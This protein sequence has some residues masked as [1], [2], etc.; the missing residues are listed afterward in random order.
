MDTRAAGRLPRDSR[1][2][3]RDA[4]PPPHRLMHRSKHKSH[5]GS[6]SSRFTPSN[7]VRGTNCRTPSA[8][9]MK[10]DVLAGSQVYD[11]TLPRRR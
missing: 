4:P 7:Q 5:D 8:E 6:W 9:R 11:I 1:G 2:P 10:S 3:A